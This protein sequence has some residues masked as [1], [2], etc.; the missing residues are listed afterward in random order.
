MA[1]A[2]DSIVPDYKN[3]VKVNTA[4]LLLSNV[5]LLYERKLNEHWT[6]L[7]GAGYRWGGSV[8]KVLGL[9]DVIVTSNSA[10]IT[11]FSFTPEI[12]YYFNFCE[13]GGSPSGLYA[14][15]YGRFTKYYGDLRFNVWNGS[16]YYEALVTSNLREFGGGLQLGYQFIFKQRWAVDFMFAGPRLSNY[17]LKADLESDDLEALVSAIEEGINERRAAIGMDP[18]SIDPSAELETNFG[19]KNFRYAIGIGFLF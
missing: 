14:G 10:G 2:Q 6:V 3:I 18:I 16:E 8:P 4:A 11:G 15:L 9:G 12:R 1:R 13:C 7:T 5:S 17:K 19:F